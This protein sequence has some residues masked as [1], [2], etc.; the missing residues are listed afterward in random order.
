MI[1]HDDKGYDHDL[2]YDQTADIYD[3]TDEESPDILVDV[4]GHAG[5]EEIFQP[6]KERIDQATEEHLQSHQSWVIGKC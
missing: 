4:V 1:L 2:I 5:N 6:E 3:H